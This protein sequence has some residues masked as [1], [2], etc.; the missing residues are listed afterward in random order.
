MTFPDWFTP[1]HPQISVASA[2]A[3]LKL[4]DEGATVPFIARYRKEE[5]GNLD[6]VAIRQV[7]D[8]KESWD[9]ILKRQTF[10][11]EEIERQGKLTPELK[12]QL[13][14]T[15][16]LTMLEDLYLPYKQKRKTRRRWRRKPGSS[17]WRAGSGSAATECC[18]PRPKTH[19][20][21]TRWRSATPTR[22]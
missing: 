2:A 8:A 12:D 4:A 19:P 1:R 22:A 6:E 17:C 16:E 15:F 9:E 14:A 13:L 7:I 18:R 3:V 10:I 11:V 21:R 5:T 20:R